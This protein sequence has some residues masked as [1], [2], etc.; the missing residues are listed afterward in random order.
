MV[1]S[2]ASWTTRPLTT[3]AAA[4]NRSEHPCPA[5]HHSIPKK[6]ARIKPYR[7]DRERFVLRP[8][9]C[10]L[11]CTAPLDGTGRSIPCVGCAQLA[12]ALYA[13]LVPGF[14]RQ[15]PESRV[16]SATYA[17][18]PFVCDHQEWESGEKASI[19]ENSRRSK[20]NPMQLR[21]FL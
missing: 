7:V 12:A 10:H 8:P 2:L 11:L 4:L 18:V 3:T 13:V 17:F 19:A 14:R 1:G 5:L 6:R 20:T 9:V 15:K 16:E 21:C